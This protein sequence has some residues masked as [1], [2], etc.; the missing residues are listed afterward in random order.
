[1]RLPLLL[2]CWLLLF[3]VYSQHDVNGTVLDEA[4]DPVVNIEIYDSISGQV[5]LSDL[6][7]GFIFEDLSAGLHRLIAFGWEFQTEQLNITVPTESA[8]IIRLK[9]LAVD[10]SA[11]EISAR[12]TQQFALR[13]LRD[14]EGTSIFAGKKSEVVVMDKV[15]G[16]LATNNSRQVYAQVAGLNIYEG[17][18]GG[19]QLGIG[20]RGLD[21]NRTSNFNTRQNGYDI[22]ADVLGYPENYYTPP[23]EAIEEI[24]VIRGASSLQ[25]G[26]QFGG[27]LNFK[28]RKIPR[29]EKFNL[30]LR[31][32]IGSFGLFNTF[33]SIGYRHQKFSVDAFVNHKRGNGYRANSEFDAT[34]IFTRVQYDLSKRT[35]MHA[36]FTYFKYLAKQAGGLTDNQFKQN[37]RLSTRER[38]WFEVDWKLLNF[39]I[40]HK[41]QQGE[42]SLNIFGLSASRQSLGYRGDPASLNQNPITAIDEQ[43]SDGTYLN[44]R[45]LIEGTFKNFGI[46]SRFLKRYL[47]GKKKSILL[48]GAKY[49]HAENTSQQGPGSVGTDADFNFRNVQFA[50]YPSQSSF[51]FPN[52]NLAIFGENIIY[53]TDKLSITPGFRYEFIRTKS[54]GTYRQV[55]FDNAGNPLANRVL[56]EERNLPRD[57]LLLGIGLSYRP[58]P[59]FD[60]YANVSQNYRSITFSDIRVVNPTFIVDPDIGDERGLTADLGVRGRIAKKVSY[61]LGVYGLVYNDRIG[62]ILDDRANRVRKNIGSA[63]ILGFESLL[64]VDIARILSDSD[65]KQWKAGIFINT[66]ITS[67]EYRSSE[68]NNVVGKEV[69]FI[70]RYNIKTG[71]QLGFKDLLA[72]IQYGYVSQQFTD[73]QNST[74]PNAGD[75]RAGIIGEIPAY[76]VMDISLS[77]DLNKFRLEAGTNNVLDEAYFTRRATGYPGPGIIPSEG[78]S[79]YLTLQYLLRHK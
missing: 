4:G 73:A 3:E 47:L 2:F 6:D 77:Y 60:W 78:R 13:R 49:Y 39:G 38:N 66:A 54:S 14:V 30:K 62:I 42:L 19:L 15:L 50:D 55:V 18:D 31:Q 79:I 27:L 23:T 43:A 59:T 34:N 45:D 35:S 21:P 26:T 67:S 32:T 1:M 33:N 70:P 44:P 64:D 8:I 37:P 51:E 10:L 58:S 74:I 11:V 28:L 71:I 36:E 72:T 68:E 46:E 29:G 16:N 56:E 61:E 76:Q 17:S 52:R 9:K 53:L 5:V 20:G 7:G 40:E 22:S 65:R 41:I 12:R 24:Q 63:L 69:E 25:Y 75:N 48:L 57:L